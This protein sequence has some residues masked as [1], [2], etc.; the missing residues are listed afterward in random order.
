[1][2]FLHYSFNDYFVDCS[3]TLSVV[4]LFCMKLSISTLIQ[5]KMRLLRKLWISFS[6]DTWMYASLTFKFNKIIILFMLIFYT[7][8]ICFVKNFSVVLHAF[9]RRLLI[10][11]SKS[12]LCVFVKLSICLTMIDFNVSFNVASDDTKAWLRQNHV[13]WLRWLCTERNNFDSNTQHI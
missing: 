3:F 11:V 12:S 1:M 7:M 13:M 2:R 5:S 4:C 9:F 10:C 8:W 6:F